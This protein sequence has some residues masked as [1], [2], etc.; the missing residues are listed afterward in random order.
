MSLE[1]TSLYKKIE[2]LKTYKEVL[3]DPIHERKW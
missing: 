1:K 3:S 2:E